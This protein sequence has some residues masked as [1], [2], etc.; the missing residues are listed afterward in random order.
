ML[1]YKSEINQK[2]KQMCL[3]QKNM[4]IV[5]LSVRKMGWEFMSHLKKASPLT[6]IVGVVV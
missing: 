4:E 1:G 3:V 6:I 5:C 2:Q